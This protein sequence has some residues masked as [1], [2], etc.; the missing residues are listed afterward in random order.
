MTTFKEH[1]SVI[2]T[3]AAGNLIDTFVVY[4]TNSKTGLTHINHMDLLVP[5]KDLQLHPKTLQSNHVPVCDTFSFEI[6]K[7]LKA[8]YTD[9]DTEIN[10]KIMSQP[11]MVAV[12]SQAS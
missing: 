6:L 3:D 10:T 4:G 2:Y 7:K 9:N 5:L 12:Y 8:K 11:A 1:D